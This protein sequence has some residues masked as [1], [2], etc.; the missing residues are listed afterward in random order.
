MRYEHFR[1][2]GALSERFAGH[3]EHAGIALTPPVPGVCPGSS[4]IGND[5]GRVPAVHPFVAI[6]DPDGS[7]HTPEVAEAAASERARRVLL[8]VVEALALTGLDVLRDPGLRGRAWED[9]RRAEG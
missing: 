6:M 9:L 3:L 4:D 5:S 2:S 8:A 7:D 1:D